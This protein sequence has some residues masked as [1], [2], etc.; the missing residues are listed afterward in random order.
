M[1]TPFSG[2]SRQKNRRGMALIITLAMLVLVTALIIALFTSITTEARSSKMYVDGN[3][4]RQFSDSVV[5][6]AISQ[7]AEATSGTS[8]GAPVAWASQ[9]GM[10]RTY[11]AAG[12]PSKFYKLYSSSSLLVEG[13]SFNAAAEMPPVNWDS[14]KGVF[15][16]LN[17]PVSRDGATIFPIVD[18]RAKAA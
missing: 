17:A 9:P 15:T 10:I 11:D 7:V 4:S 8:A 18:P 14:M 1:R 13:N 3:R 6:I 16:D 5:Q 12:N 2:A